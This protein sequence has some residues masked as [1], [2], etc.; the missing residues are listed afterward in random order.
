MKTFP[1]T[2]LEPVPSHTKSG[3][4]QIFL[5]REDL[6]PFGGGNKVRRFAAWFER[7]PGLRK[8]GVLSDRG[9]HTFWVLSQM[10][11]F[12][13]ALDRHLSFV[14]WERRRALNP[15]VKRLQQGYLP[16]PR[17]E[18][19]TGPFFWLALK[20]LK[21]KYFSGKRTATLGIGGQAPGVEE[22]YAE[23]MREC[24]EQLNAAGVSGKRVWHLFPVA[25]GNMADG[26]LRF[27]RQAKLENHRICGILTGPR[28]SRAWMRLKYFFEPRVLLK[29]RRRVTWPRYERAAQD[30]FNRT[31]V[32]L[33]PRHTASAWRSLATLPQEI[34]SDDVLVFWVTCPLI[35]AAD[36][37][38]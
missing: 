19:V 4:P 31:G 13:R 22:A 30:C 26:F 27:F 15:Y 16:H 3:A 38:G 11:S 6:L 23:A 18:V 8:V 32:W 14:F 21:M 24:V 29:R 2:P 36:F 35:A 37:A 17:I 20:Y 7:H 28:P 5:K 1:A 34:A 12:E 33:D 9:S 25:S 10:L